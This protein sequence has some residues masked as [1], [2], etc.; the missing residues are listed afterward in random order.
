MLDVVIDTSRI[1]MMLR[2][3]EHRVGMSLTKCFG[4]CL[5][6]VNCT[7]CVGKDALTTRVEHDMTRRVAVVGGDC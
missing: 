1:N 2:W 3:T 7:S 5:A 4:Q 6:T